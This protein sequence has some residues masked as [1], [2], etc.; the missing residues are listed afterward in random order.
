M[1]PVQ[2]HNQITRRAPKRIHLLAHLSTSLSCTL[3]PRA[4]HSLR[5]LFKVQGSPPIR[6]PPRKTCLHHRW[7][8][9]H[10]LLHPLPRASR[11]P[12]H[13][14][15][16]SNTP[17]SART[18]ARTVHLSHAA[19]ASQTLL[20]SQLG[21]H[22]ACTFHVSKA[23]PAASLMC[24][25]QSRLHLSVEGFKASTA[26]IV[27]R[28]LHAKL[29]S[30][31]AKRRQHGSMHGPCMPGCRH[32]GA[33]RGARRCHPAR[34]CSSCEKGGHLPCVRACNVERRRAGR[35]SISVLSKKTLCQVMHVGL[36]RGAWSKC[37][38]KLLMRQPAEAHASM[39]G[40]QAKQAR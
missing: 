2:C 33:L 9:C 37:S 3:W 25:K 30:G 18:Y 4:R 27:T 21:L 34:G 15:V 10:M 7:A 22:P 8:A 23:A 13:V 31:H 38:C 17:P 39:Q 1:L 16:T 32:E 5:P 12:A 35:K 6:P 14:Q 19:S 28:P 20:H 24:Q 29:S 36:M 26:R 40:A 11:H